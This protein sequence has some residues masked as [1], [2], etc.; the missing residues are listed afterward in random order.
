LNCGY[1]IRDDPGPSTISTVTIVIY[2]VGKDGTFVGQKQRLAMTMDFKE[3]DTNFIKLK[4]NIIQYCGIQQ[5]A[6]DRYWSQF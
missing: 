5:E 1:E 2:Y 6:I 3:K 4:H